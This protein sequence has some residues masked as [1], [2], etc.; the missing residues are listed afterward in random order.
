[1][2]EEEEEEEE[3]ESYADECTVTVRKEAIANILYKCAKNDIDKIT[4]HAL[5]L[6][7]DQ[8]EC[9]LFMKY[10][11]ESFL[12]N[13]YEC[14]CSESTPYEERCTPIENFYGWIFPKNF[15]KCQFM[16]STLA[17]RIQ[18]I[19]QKSNRGLIQRTSIHELLSL[20]PVHFRDDVISL[21]QVN[22]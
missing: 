2:E 18:N 7:E 17:T 20:I 16:A 14:E 10:Y 12:P 9:Y 19:L 1:M 21:L 11:F 3:E 13:S 15:S 5:D 4:D 6:F 8:E 22:C